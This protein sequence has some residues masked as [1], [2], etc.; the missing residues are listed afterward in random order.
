MYFSWKVP[1]LTLDDGDGRIEAV[2]RKLDRFLS[3][4]DVVRAYGGLDE[5]PVFIG[6]K[7]RPRP[8]PRP[9]PY[10]KAPEL[11]PMRFGTI[12]AQKLP[13]PDITVRREGDTL[14]TIASKS[15]DLVFNDPDTAMGQ[16]EILADN[17]VIWINEKKMKE[18][19]DARKSE[20]QIYAEGHVVVHH[21]GRTI[22]CERLFYDYARQKAL[23]IGGPE[24]YAVIQGHHGETQI[25]YYY[26]AKAFR[27]LNRDNFRADNCRITTSEFGHPEWYVSVKRMDLKIGREMVPDAS[28]RP[29]EEV[30]S[31]KAVFHHSVF[32]A[33]G[34]PLAYLPYWSHN[35]K[36]DR[37]LL[38]RFTLGSS[39]DLGT[40]V[41]T[42]WD[43]YALGFYENDWSQPVVLLDY[44]SDRGL[45]YGL[46]LE[47]ARADTNG[48][49][50]GYHINDNGT[51]NSGVPLDGRSRGRIRWLHRQLLSDYWRLDTE[52]SYLSDAGFLNEYFEKEFKED[53]AQETMA[54]LRYA[55][56]NFG[57]TALA[58]GRINSF[59]TE[60]E[61]L[62]EVRALLVGQPILGNRLVYSTDNR[63]GFLRR[64][65]DDR[66]AGLPGD[67]DSLRLDS[68]HELQLPF[69][70][71]P[72]KLAP[73]V[74]ARFTAYG[75]NVL[76][77]SDDRTLLSG[78]V[79]ASSRIWRVY[80]VQSRLWGLNGIRHVMVPNVEYIRTFVSST[81]AARL[82][83]FDGIDALDKSSI[84][85]F[86]LFQRWQTKRPRRKVVPT[87]PADWRVVDWM[88][89]DAGIDF[90]PD[91][92]RDHGGRDLSDLTLEYIFRISDRMTLLADSDIDLDDD[93]RFETATIGVNLNRS[94]RFSVYLGQR[95]IRTG[96]SNTTIGRLEYKVD[97]RWK[98][99]MLGNYD[100]ATGQSNDVRLTLTRVLHDWELR[101]GF[102]RDSGEDDTT[103]MLEFA[104][105]WVPTF[106][107]RL[108]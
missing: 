46:E 62:P 102:E 32:K 98:V 84:V 100:W 12:Y 104:P 38:K 39:S 30:V 11:Q 88:T 47:Y 5:V 1:G 60:I 54:Y 40:E 108:F 29:A 77:R 99:G 93:K 79:R 48:Y 7:H 55:R 31:E 89:L 68:A 65:Q 87:G 70:V 73:F 57:F 97:E 105:V 74:G 3:H 92:D 58:R 91:A 82:P 13:M 96:D 61:Y 8:V 81:P 19:G 71:G 43:P 36:R 28:G 26:H 45:A 37:A 15:P 67:Y 44:F 80:D 18:T 16:L 2:S 86:G 21:R 20:L 23:I 25:P 27:Q 14:I 69:R 103:F 76:G 83:Q 41:R 24:G 64:R 33:G 50:H 56:D 51:D 75:R 106:Q 78:G 72:V 49:F 90:Y 94:P 95:Y 4:G 42:G 34:I 85:R 63:L 101:M 10:A 6:P 53:K 9:R 35:L 59:T 107:F 66:L 52:L 17:A 22:R